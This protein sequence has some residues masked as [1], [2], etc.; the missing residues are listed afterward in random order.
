MLQY[1][2]VSIFKKKQENYD[3]IALMTRSTEKNYLK[4]IQ[5]ELCFFTGRRMNLPF[6]KIFQIAVGEQSINDESFVSTLRGQIE[7]KAFLCTS[8][9]KT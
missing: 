2:L 5:R 9:N 8:D 3:Y 1:G 7:K 6:L 4:E